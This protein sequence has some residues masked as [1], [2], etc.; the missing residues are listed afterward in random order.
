[1]I[2]AQLTTEIFGLFAPARTDIAYKLADLPIRVTAAKEAASI[3]HFYVH[4]HS[5]AAVPKPKL[6]INE[7][8]QWMANEARISLPDSAYPAKMYDFVYT[9]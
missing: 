9:L 3:A 2:D 7:K 8:I 1:M 4:M 6:A 5:L